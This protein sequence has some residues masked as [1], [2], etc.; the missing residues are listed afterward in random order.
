MKKIILVFAIYCLVSS[1]NY[2]KLNDDFAPTAE[3]KY[4]VSIDQAIT[5]ASNVHK[6][7]LLNKSLLK[8]QQGRIQSKT[9]KNSITI[10]IPKT[11]LTS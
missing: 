4:D 10:P 7:E 9:V 11:R 3:L 5:A 6:S 2:K 1:C 8:K